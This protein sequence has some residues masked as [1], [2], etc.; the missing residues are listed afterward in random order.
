M[1]DPEVR[2]KVKADAEV[3]K[4]SFNEVSKSAKESADA[5]IAAG[6][7]IE[8]ADKE[9][10]DEL[11]KAQAEKVRAW[12]E[13]KEAAKRAADEAAAA[14]QKAANDRAAFIRGLNDKRKS[15]ADYAREIPVVGRALDLLKNPVVLLAGAFTTLAGV[16]KRGIGEFAQAEEQSARLDAALARSGQLTDQYR[17]SLHDLA[18]QLQQTTGIADDQWLE[19]LRKLTQFGATEGTIGQAAEAVKNLAGIMD[20]DLA[21]A[22]NLVGRAL[23]GNFEVLGRYGIEA[24]NLTELFKE[25]S[26][27]GAG[28][29]DVR[30]ETLIGTWGRLKNAT[31][32][33]F[34]SIG[35]LIN[36]SGLLK[37]G[38]EAIIN[39]FEWWNDRIGESI[40]RVKGLTNAVDDQAAAQAAAATAT[41]AN[42]EA[43]AQLDDKL[44]SITKNLQDQDALLNKRKSRADRVAAAAERAELALIDASGLSPAAKEFAKFQTTSRYAEAAQNR[45]NVLVSQQAAE[46]RAAIDRLSLEDRQLATE[47]SGIASRLPEQEAQE[48]KNELVRRARAEL[49]ALEYGDLQSPDVAVFAQASTRAH[50]IRGFLAGA[51]ETPT[52]LAA[53][54]LRA[55]TIATRRAEI[56]GLR[57]NS[58][59]EYRAFE[60][61]GV[62]G[63]DAR[64]AEGRFD[65]IARTA[66]AFNA[67]GGQRTAAKG[68]A[69]QGIISGGGLQEAQ[70]QYLAEV[71]QLFRAMKKQLDEARDNLRRDRDGR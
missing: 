57:S 15:M 33:L 2:I 35:G 43:N 42:A 70:Q 46:R 24:K 5:I 8:Q 44:K 12:K 17:A 22:A 67:I 64:A 28:Q 61:E 59:A 32:D 39:A 4:K 21:G 63:F 10:R 54:R 58:L 19:A 34:E 18:G 20:G 3:A 52:T 50:A 13:E 7:R 36:R 47:A 1:A 60:Q 53:D 45:E 23:Q 41:K 51:T 6:K 48:K 55:Q 38:L 16:M 14:E 30:S 25:L 29:L 37:G 68:Q 49:E 66:G 9:R 65:R 71:D 11:L 27:K 56:A 69:V 62:E 40:P 31:N 26:E